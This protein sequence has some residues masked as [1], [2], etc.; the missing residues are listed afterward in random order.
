MMRA[1]V[2]TTIIFAP[3]RTESTGHLQSQRIGQNDTCDLRS[4]ERIV[5]NP[6]A[7]FDVVAGETLANMASAAWFSPTN[8]RAAAIA[9]LVATF[10]PMA[11]EIFMEIPQRVP[12]LTKLQ[13]CS[14][15]L[16]PLSHQWVTC[17]QPCG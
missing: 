7:A 16:W 5:A 14:E 12:P 8:I 2:P 6:M 11:I 17:D 9:Q 13:Q 3:I 1:S 15:Q 4:V 10:F